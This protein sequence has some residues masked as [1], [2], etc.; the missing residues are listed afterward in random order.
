MVK[1]VYKCR[2]CGYENEISN[3]PW[4]I[5]IDIPCGGCGEFMVIMKGE[6]D[7][8]KSDERVQGAAASE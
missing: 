2:K 6:E 3:M 5:K 1:T 8:H 7:V 4:G